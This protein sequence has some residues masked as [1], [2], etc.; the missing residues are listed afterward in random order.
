MDPLA[1]GSTFPAWLGP[2]WLPMIPTVPALLS[3][4]DECSHPS[5]RASLAT[6]L[7]RIT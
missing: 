6:L 7:A 1:E 2:F 3:E 5:P 4:G